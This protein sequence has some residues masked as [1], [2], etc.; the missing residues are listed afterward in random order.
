VTQAA[1]VQTAVDTRAAQG[2]GRSL[3][4]LFNVSGHVDFRN[5]WQLA[6]VEPSTRYRLS[7]FVRTGELNSAATLYAVVS[8][9]ANESQVFGQS[10]AA[11]TGTHEWQ[12]LSFDFSTGAKTEAVV[13]RL[14]RVGC[15]EQTCPIYGKIWYDDFD[16]RRAAAR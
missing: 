13:V 1:G 15:P 4:L 11:P 2:G 3:R 14:V 6:V 8:D 12:Q 9:A 5:L 16:L 10:A 7:Y